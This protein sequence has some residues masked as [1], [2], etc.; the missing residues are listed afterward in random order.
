MILARCE[1]LD[2][3]AWSWRARPATLRGG[4]S[5]KAVRFHGR[6]AEPR[7][8]RGPPT[9]GSHAPRV[10]QARGPACVEEYPDRWRRF[11]RTCRFQAKRLVRCPSANQVSHR[12]RCDVS[13]YRRRH[14]RNAGLRS[15]PDKLRRCRRSR[16]GLQHECAVLLLIGRNRSALRLQVFD[17]CAAAP[18]VVS[19]RQPARDRCPPR[20]HVG[21]RSVYRFMTHGVGRTGTGP[22]SFVGAGGASVA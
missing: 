11:P 9:I 20:I 14:R 4:P 10:G 16:R 3:Y 19:A 22:P 21:R 2:G 18:T 5:A 1:L 7:M 12:P 8:E 13:G 15:C 17:G 6:E